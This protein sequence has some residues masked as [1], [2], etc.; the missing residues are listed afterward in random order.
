MV[1]GGKIVANISVDGVCGK[2]FATILL[3]LW[4]I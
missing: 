4:L 1:S 2:I 3:H